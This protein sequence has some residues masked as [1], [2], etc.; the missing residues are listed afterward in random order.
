MKN[1][2]KLFVAASLVM[3]F[4]SAQV[5]FTEGIT[6]LD[7]GQAI[8]SCVPRST[9]YGYLSAR[10]QGDAHLLQ[11]IKG[12]TIRHAERIKTD[13][14]KGEEAEEKYGSVTLIQSSG[15]LKTVQLDQWTKEGL[16]CVKMALNGN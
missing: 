4:S 15:V 3:S 13:W 8:I 9:D 6:S 16:A 1:Q 7:D 12:V 11:S 14:E 10:I 2:M 5:E